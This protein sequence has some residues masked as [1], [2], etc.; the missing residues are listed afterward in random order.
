MTAQK[1]KRILTKDELQRPFVDVDGHDRLPV[2]SP[3][4]LA[5]L[6]GVSTKTIY[7]WIAAGRLDGTFRKRGKHVLIW[8]DRA[9]DTLFNGP[10]WTDD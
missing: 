3:A 2:I 4:Q 8:R 1:R 9:L 6:C 7:H 10:D 5:A